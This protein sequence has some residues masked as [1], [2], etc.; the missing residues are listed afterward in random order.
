MVIQSFFSH[1]YAKIQCGTDGSYNATSYTDPICTQG[2]TTQTALQQNACI[3][4]AGVRIQCSQIYNDPNLVAYYI[5]Q[6]DTT[7]NAIQVPTGTAACTSRGAGHYFQIFCDSSSST[8]SL[9]AFFDSSCTQT[10][11]ITFSQPNGS[12]QPNFGSFSCGAPTTPVPTTHAP[13]TIAIATTAIPSTSIPTTV[14]ATSTSAPTSTSTPTTI[15]ATSSP[16][17]TAAVNGTLA[18]SS[19]SSTSIWLTGYGPY[20][21]AAITLVGCGVILFSAWYCAYQPRYQRLK[22]RGS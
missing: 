2:A 12:C 20:L 17:T 8:Y 13:T 11:N 18:A 10:N 19:R 6:C 21:L 9:A 15:H 3:S 4:P 1:T 16:V 14:T 7:I 5:F 22:P